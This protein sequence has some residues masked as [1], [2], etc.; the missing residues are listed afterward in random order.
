MIVTGGDAFF[1]AQARGMGD[2]KL[3]RI[4]S[5]IRERFT[6]TSGKAGLYSTRMILP[7]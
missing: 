6:T 2:D 7:G 4:I 3:S 1:C 5:E